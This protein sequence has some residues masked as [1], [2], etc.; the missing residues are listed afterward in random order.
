MPLPLLP[1]TPGA[2]AYAPKN[3]LLLLIALI[4]LSFLVDEIGI[5]TQVRCDELSNALLQFARFRRSTTESRSWT[6]AY[7]LRPDEGG[8]RSSAIRQM[9][10]AD[11]ADPATSTWSAWL[12]HRHLW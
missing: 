8:L 9:D 1:R 6:P 12:P 3:S 7:F 11:L 4:D 10:G 5:V 2:A